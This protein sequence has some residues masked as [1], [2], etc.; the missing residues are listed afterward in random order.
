MKFVE[1]HM[2]ALYYFVLGLTI[3]LP[4]GRWLFTPSQPESTHRRAS[5]FSAA[6][7]L[8]L[9]S[10]TLAYSVP[11]AHAQMYHESLQ[12]RTHD[13]IIMLEVIFYSFADILLT[14]DLIWN[15]LGH[16]TATKC[17]WVHLQSINYFISRILSLPLAAA[18]VYDIIL[19]W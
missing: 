19:V 8:G 5:L 10:F 2:D 16:N 15:N 3:L 9:L 7:G 6:I 11:L 14:T 18:L 4:Y 1:V 17:R 12:T 13:T